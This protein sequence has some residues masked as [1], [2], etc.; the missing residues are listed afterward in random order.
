M[1]PVAGVLVI[2]LAA[3][4]CATT[5]A[6]P[7]ARSRADLIN[8]LVSPAYSQWLVGPIVVMATPDEVAAYLELASDE[9]AAAFIEDFWERR[10]PYPLREDN[11]LRA[12][13]EARA[14]EADRLYAE[15]GYLGRRTARGIVHVLFGEPAATDFE[16]SP[17]PDDPAI[18]RWEYPADAPPGLHGR[19][20]DR[21]YRF[22]KRGELTELYVPRGS[23]ARSRPDLERP[24]P[25]QP[26]GGLP[27]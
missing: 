3:A 26:P 20:P 2:V 15:G 16:V 18:I 24:R 4:G 27:P 25:V 11:P 9:A 22:V 12:L 21:V 6:R 17:H 5:D 10:K 19:R 8:T 1:A 7:P 13:F 14:A 23:S